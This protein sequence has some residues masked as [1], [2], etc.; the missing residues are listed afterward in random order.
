MPFALRRWL[1][2]AASTSLLLSGIAEAAWKTEVVDTYHVGKFSSMAVDAS[3]TVHISY[4]DAANGNVKYAVNSIGTW[5]TEVVAPVGTASLWAY[6][7]IA[8]DAGGAPQIVYYDDNQDALRLA[9]KSNGAWLTETVDSGAGG[10]TAF[11]PS[12]A[13]DSSGKPH[14]SYMFNQG[15]S[16]SGNLRY[17]VKSGSAWSV[18]TVDTDGN[19][20]FHTSIA[21]DSSG[22][23]HISYVRYPA[24]GNLSSSIL[25][26]ATRAS[27]TAA[28]TIEDVDSSV[29]VTHT[30]IALDA[31]GVPQISYHDW[32]N[33][34]LLYATRGGGSWTI[35]SVDRT[36]N[37]GRYS[38]IAV[39]PTGTPH[40]S[41]YDITNQRL[42]YATLGAQGWTN[43]VVDSAGAVGSYSDIALDPSGRPHISYYDSTVPF[44]LKHAVAIPPPDRQPPAGEVVQLSPR[45]FPY[46]VTV[47]TRCAESFLRLCLRTEITR[48]CVGGNCF[49]VRDPR[50]P[51]CLR[52]RLALSAAI[53]IGAGVIGGM[54]LAGRR[55]RPGRASPPP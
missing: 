31:T 34:Y 5:H 2:A 51:I 36:A 6:T 35:A 8:V 9:A 12:I 45:E 47:E 46:K 39:A 49:D 10:I 28:W 1:L 14:V 21:V 32:D 38:S 4:Y 25:K 53:G 30:A 50:G 16:A 41:Y 40:I 23:P 15:S 24:P 18:Q 26:Y 27:V 37:V 55:P 44:A 52:C 19:T 43:E 33:G 13:V 48:V 29:P 22:R 20:G 54:L 17:A 3:G 11:F 7:S 42:K